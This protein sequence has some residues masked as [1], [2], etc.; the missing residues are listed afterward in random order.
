[1]TTTSK[2]WLRFGAGLAIVVFALLLQAAIGADHELPRSTLDMAVHG[3]VECVD[4]EGC[5]MLHRC[6]RPEAWTDEY[7]DPLNDY[8]M[9][10]AGELRSLPA[11]ADASLSCVVRVEGEANVRAVVSHMAHGAVVSRELVEVA[12][13]GSVHGADAS[14]E[15]VP[16]GHVDAACTGD[17]PGYVR[18][19]A[20]QGCGYR[21]TPYA[22]CLEKLVQEGVREDALVK[23]SVRTFSFAESS[24]GLQATWDVH[25]G[26]TT[27][28]VDKG[29][30][31]TFHDRDLHWRT[32]RV[33]GDRTTTV[34]VTVRKSGGLC[35]T[36]RVRLRVRD[37]D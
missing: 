1:M 14:D 34:S 7:D 35:A 6:Q 24:C 16:E 3:D 31:C 37:T 28:S 19:S 36:D 8:G 2:R 21:Y 26:G 11:T 15:D 20:F 9:F 33:D 30:P 25:G 12:R 22:S 5:R 27:E 29:T 4:P 17:S 10:Y 18:I 13:V 32:P 23:F